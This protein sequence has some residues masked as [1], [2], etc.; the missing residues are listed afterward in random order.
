G[1]AD[2]YDAMTTA[3][4]YRGPML[5]HEAVESLYAGSGK[6]YQQHLLER[7]RDRI[8][9]YP[10]GLTVTLN[11]AE[12]GVVSR[13]GGTYAHRPVVRLLTDRDGQPLAATYEI[14]LS[15]QLSTMIVG[16]AE[17]DEDL[18]VTRS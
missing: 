4:V 8:V 1:I 5:P 11:T 10:I 3:R 2:S 13:I 15:E 17:L 14:D 12:T 7:F 16:R 18:L 6:L 9:I